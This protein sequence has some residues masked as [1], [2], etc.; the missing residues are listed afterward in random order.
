MAAT[1]CD[2]SQNHH[3]SILGLSREMETLYAEFSPRPRDFLYILD[4]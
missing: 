3:D 2:V 1:L 4:D